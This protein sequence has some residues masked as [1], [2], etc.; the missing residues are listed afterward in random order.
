M[1]LIQTYAEA[2][3]E[4]P[5]QEVVFNYITTLEFPGIV[6]IIVSFAFQTTSEIFATHCI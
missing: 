6:V 4:Y 2:N 3:Q 1:N 5:A